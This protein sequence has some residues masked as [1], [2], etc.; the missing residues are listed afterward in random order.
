[1]STMMSTR[2]RPAAGRPWGVAL[3]LLT[4]LCGLP[5]AL[6]QAPAAKAAKVQAPAAAS[7]EV[8]YRSGAEDVRGYLALPPASKAARRPAVILVHEWWGQNDWV[9]EQ[10][11]RFA[12][13]G[14][15]ALSVDLYRGSVAADADTAHQLMRGLP[16]DR[17]LRDLAA[18]FT[19]LAGR[20]DVDA[21]RIGAVGWCM[22]GGYALA[23]ALQEPKLAA[24]VIYYGRLA[25]DRDK[26]GKIKAALLGNFGAEDKGIPAASVTA[27]AEGARAAGVRADFKI[28][29]AVGHAFAS[30]KDPKV[31][32]P[33]AAKEADARTDAFF[34]QH[35]RP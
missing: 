22:G 21:A 27:F 23:E 35:L 29:P 25:T 11:R 28:F 12:Q 4:S 33:A 1:M 8:S 24:A 34:A 20:K 18:A 9:K 30:S 10:A 31:Y 2:P 3:A 19:Y 7:N 14:Y 6:A 15:V 16:E 5:Q 13:Q 26:I 17:A 32:N